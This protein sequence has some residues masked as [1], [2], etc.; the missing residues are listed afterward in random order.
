MPDEIW[1]VRT[2][3]PNKLESPVVSAGGSARSNMGSI[4]TKRTLKHLLIPVLLLMAS[5]A[6][7]DAKV[8][9]NPMNLDPQVREAYHYFYLLDYPA[10]VERFH[11]IH[12]QHPGDPHATAMLLNAMVFQELYR[13]DLLDTT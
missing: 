8:H 10:A 13:Q 4:T 7:A 5:R 2:P 12:Q 6:W 11:Q 1:D 3:A 9:T